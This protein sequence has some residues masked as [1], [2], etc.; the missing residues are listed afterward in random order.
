MHSTIKE[1]TM[2]HA[3]NLNDQQLNVIET[4]TR[5]FSIDPQ[6]FLQQAIDDQIEHVEETLVKS[7][8]IVWG[9]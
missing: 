1:I 5:V 7:G 4:A 8:H 9:D 3:I 2:Q 6:E